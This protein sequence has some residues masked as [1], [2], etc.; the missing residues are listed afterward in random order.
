MVALGPRLT[1]YPAHD[2]FCAW[3]ADEFVRAGLT[4]VP[5]DE[6]EY[7]RWR[8][9]RVGLELLDGRRRERVPVASR[10][11][12]SASTPRHGVTAPLAY[13]GVMPV[14]DAVG[15]LTGQ[16]SAEDQ[17]RLRAWTASLGDSLRGRIAVVDLP[18]PITLN[19]GIFTFVSTYLQWD[20]H[21]AADWAAIDFTRPWIGPWPALGTFAELGAA[22]VVFVVDAGPDLLTGNDSPHTSRPQPVPALLVDRDTGG[23]L[24]E[25]AKRGARARLTLFAP[26][27]RVRIR[28]V[29]AVLPGESDE[30]V[31]VHSHSDGQNAFEE[32]GAVALVGMARHFASLP[33]GERPRRTLVFAAWP[34]H[35]SG[36]E[37][38]E[39]ASCWIAAHPDLCARAVGA[40]SV[41]HL[42]ATEWV[43]TPERGYHATGENEVYAIWA[44]Q[45][46]MRDLAQAALVR[47]GLQRHALLKPP[48]QIT[49]GAPFH[50][51]GIPHVAGIA[52]P[53]YLLVVSPNGELDKLDH[54]LAA[55]QIAFYADVVRQIDG[56][57]AEALR[58]G[59]PTLGANPPTYEDESRPVR[60][61]P[62]R[63]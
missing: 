6:Y 47:S 1:G 4:L 50:D 27:R 49:P 52:G 56:A 23:S 59:D 63:R 35:M 62:R 42:G 19:A 34:G 18:V 45:S 21:T 51:A 15:A 11:V 53:T 48:L 32:N 38:I 29:T 57:P 43:E 60:C 2:R 41:E 16:P 24:R 39:N 44:T 61:G 30:V 58:T 20:G 25:R 28:S 5:C 26:T 12:R 9:R 31:V 55:R 8:P 14:P 7:D 3:L 13:A 10:Y 37:G 17:A 22:A 54:H 36:V 33:A 40:V 46:L